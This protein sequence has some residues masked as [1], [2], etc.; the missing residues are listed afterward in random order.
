MEQLSSTIL[1]RLVVRSAPKFSLVPRLTPRRERLLKHRVPRQV[2]VRKAHAPTHRAQ[3][4]QRRVALQTRR[5]DGHGVAPAHEV[6]ALQALAHIGVGRAEVLQDALG[7][8]LPVG[9]Q[10]RGAVG[11]GQRGVGGDELRACAG[12]IR[13]QAL[14]LG[15]DVAEAGAAVDDVVPGGWGTGLLYQWAFQL[16]VSH[17]PG[18]VADQGS[19]FLQCGGRRLQQAPRDEEGHG[20]H[21]G[22]GAPRFGAAL[23][24]IKGQ[25]ADAV[26]VF[27]HGQGGA[28]GVDAAG[29]WGCEL[30]G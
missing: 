30:V 6:D 26:A 29:Q 27:A 5:G 13:A 14:V 15:V 24:F 9:L 28:A 4:H 19:G 22:V 3:R 12:G 8:G 17:Q 20:Q 16:Q 10:Q 7:P 1:G 23:G 21:H 2:A 25:H 11:G 18:C